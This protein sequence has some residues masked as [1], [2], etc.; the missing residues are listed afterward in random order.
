MLAENNELEYLLNVTDVWEDEEDNQVS[1]N[2]YWN[3]L[4]PI[5]LWCY[6][7]EDSLSFFIYL[8]ITSILSSIKKTTGHKCQ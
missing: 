1:I 7:K 8:T 4:G 2:A 6:K 5:Y 3:W